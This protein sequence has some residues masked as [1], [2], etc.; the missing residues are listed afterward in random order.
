MS[1]HGSPRVEDRRS[2][3]DSSAF[4]YRLDEEVA[5]VRR[6]GGFLS[7][8]LIHVAAPGTPGGPD[9]ARRLSSVAERLRRAVRLEDILGQRAS[10]V[11]LLMPDTTTSQ[12]AR[13]AERLLAIANKTGAA[14][15]GTDV[16]ASAGLAT[17]YGEVEGGG[18]ALLAAAEEALKEAAPGQFARSRTLEGRPRLLVVDDDPTFAETLAEAISERGWEGHPCT[19]VGDAR[20]RVK[21]ATYSGF[22]IDVVLP[23]SS[24]IEILTEAM[25]TE[26]RRPA[27]LMSGHDID[28]ERI[29]DALALGPVMFMRKPLSLADLDTALEMFRKL[30]PGIRRRA[31]GGP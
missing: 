19:D 4:R 5:R 1:D 22:F 26:T 6:S 2:I 31:R 28:A 24:G 23:K 11:A 10:H 16:L 9:S 3:L 14:P 18:A 17:T 25:A 27:V 30:G 13:A 29:L 12:A 20:Q 21:D 8:A 7:L 15:P